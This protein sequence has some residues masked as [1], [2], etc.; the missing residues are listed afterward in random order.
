MQA[1]QWALA[2]LLMLL[3]FNTTANSSWQL[4]QEKLNIRVEYQKK[5]R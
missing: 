4:Y 5:N 3:S 1:K 2:C